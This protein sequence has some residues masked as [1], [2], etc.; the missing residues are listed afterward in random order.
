MEKYIG[1]IT[2]LASGLLAAI[3]A[4]TVQLY[5]I[6]TSRKHK[7]EG[8]VLDTKEKMLEKSDAIIAKLNRILIFFDHDQ[9]LKY[10]DSTEFNDAFDEVTNSVSDISGSMRL[11]GVSE[12]L[13]NELEKISIHAGIYWRGFSPL[14]AKHDDVGYLNSL[15]IPAN[16]F[17]SASEAEKIINKVKGALVVLMAENKK[18]PE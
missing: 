7:L 16:A 11:V 10:S 17:E 15:R 6:R 9:A 14:V 1:L 3:L 4:A 18:L 13:V 8:R 12:C 5:S 2:A